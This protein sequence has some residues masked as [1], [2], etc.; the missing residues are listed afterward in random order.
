MKLLIALLL[1]SSALADT[2]SW[3]PITLDIYGRPL[4]GPVTYQLYRDGVA[5]GPV[6]LSNSVVV[7]SCEQHIYTVTAI[8]GLESKP[9]NAVKPF[10]CVPASPTISNVPSAKLAACFLDGIHKDTALAI[11]KSQLSAG[12][13]K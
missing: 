8:S 9:S 6:L 5:A 3:Q 4:T 1:S 10:T 2:L 11:C 13:I 7:V 12:G